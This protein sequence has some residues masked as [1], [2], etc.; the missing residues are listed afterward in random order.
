MGI[1]VVLMEV[2]ATAVLL[3]FLL[4]FRQVMPEEIRWPGIGFAAALGKKALVKKEAKQAARQAKKGQPAGKAKLV[5]ND[6]LIQKA[7]Q[8]EETQLPEKTDDGNEVAQTKELPVSNISRR[9]SKPELVVILV[10]ALVFSG[11]AYTVINTRVALPLEAVKI[12]LTYVAVLLAAAVDYKTHLVPN[13]V[14][15]SAFAIRFLLYLIEY[16]ASP[17]EF[18]QLVLSSFLGFCFCFGILLIISMLTKGG[19]GFGDVKL[20]SLIGLACG[21][22]WAFGTL[23]YSVLISFFAALFL[24]LTKKKTRKQAMPFGPFIYMGYVLTLLFAVL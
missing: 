20:M 10:A 5:E 7:E 24:L 17:E 6:S 8:K 1:F 21:I 2:L 14:V 13:G 22:S 3:L 4:A 15:F 16:F 23:F 9:F 11:V 12:T 18:P 19:L